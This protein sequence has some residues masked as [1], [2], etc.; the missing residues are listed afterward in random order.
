[1]T[2][3]HKL[4]LIVGFALVLVV[5]VLVSDHFSSARKSQPG[6]GMSVLGPRD[7]GAAEPLSRPTDN[8][9]GRDFVANTGNSDY[10][11]MPSTQPPTIAAATPTEIYAPVGNPRQEPIYQPDTLPGQQ[12]VAINDPMQPQ[13]YG[14][15]PSVLGGAQRPE[16]TQIVMGGQTQ[17]SLGAGLPQHGALTTTDRVLVPVPSDHFE[18]ATP[19]PIIVEPRPQTPAPSPVTP[20]VVEP[21]KPSLPLSKG[22]L[23]RRSVKEG[24]TLYTLSQEFYGDGNLW[25]KLKEYNKGKVGANG[26]VREGVTLNF[27]PKDVLQGRASLADGTNAVPASS[28]QTAVTPAPRG[29]Q[30]ANT[31]ISGATARTA[32]GAAKTYTFQKGDVLSTVAQ[33][34][35]GSSRRWQELVDANPSVLDDPDNIPVGTVIKIPA[36]PSR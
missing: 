19:R 34:T 33:K 5:G 8:A 12:S 17:G 3:E 11:G 21:T 30:A 36:S 27:P 18:P 32:A 35:L 15:Q 1:M 13:P 28:T 26:S 2:R 7:S 29:T 22:K 25:S 14:G 16:P 31:T 6:G 10:S 24:E 23:Q 20:Q 9:A 4:A